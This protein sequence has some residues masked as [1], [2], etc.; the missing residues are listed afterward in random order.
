MNN[1]TFTSIGQ[2]IPCLLS[3]GSRGCQWKWSRF[4]IT[5]A[6]AVDVD[7]SRAGEFG[8]NTQWSG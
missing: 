2:L 1:R 8:Q 3:W 4:S 5:M 7:A 6:F